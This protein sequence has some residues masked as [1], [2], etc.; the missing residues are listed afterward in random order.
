MKDTKCCLCLTKSVLWFKWLINIAFLSLYAYLYYVNTYLRTVH[1]CCYSDSLTLTSA[2]PDLM[3]DDLTNV[4][5]YT[6]KTIAVLFWGTALS[7]LFTLISDIMTCCPHS[8][9]TECVQSL[10]FGCLHCIL[11][12]VQFA[13]W[14]MVLISGFGKE[15]RA[16]SMTVE[17]MADDGWEESQINKAIEYMNP[18]TGSILHA[19]AIWNVVYP[20]LILM[21]VAILYCVVSCEVQKAESSPGKCLLDIFECFL[22]KTIA[23]KLTAIQNKMPK[24]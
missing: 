1:S 22:P 13:A 9:S 24:K 8:G 15:G 3:T 16:C 7:H 20:C 14:I 17:E 23:R 11:Y 2:C 6:D 4:T 21:I 10:V 19:L 5:E 12:V 18:T